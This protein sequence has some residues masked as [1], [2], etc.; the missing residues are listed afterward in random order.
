MDAGDSMLRFSA[1]M[2]VCVV[3]VVVGGCSRPGA[4]PQLYPVSGKVT[5]DGKPIESGEIIFSAADGSH[6]AGGQIEDGE[7]ALRASAGRKR[8]QIT[9]MRDVPGE[10]REDNPGERVQVR[11]QYIP[12]QYNSQS[13]LE[14]NIE[15]ARDDVIFDL[16]P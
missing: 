14:V 6:V 11:E 9:A 16:A 2:M 4:G 1:G 12:P 5:L 10:F 15:K 7:Y 8:V 13:T 3:L